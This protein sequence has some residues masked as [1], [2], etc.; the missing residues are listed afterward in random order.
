MRGR[1]DVGDCG[2]GPGRGNGWDDVVEVTRSAGS[3]SQMLLLRLWRRD[4]SRRSPGVALDLDLIASTVTEHR[5]SLVMKLAGAVIC[6]SATARRYC[7]GWNSWCSV[8]THGPIATEP[9]RSTRASEAHNLALRRRATLT[10]RWARA[11]IPWPHLVVGHCS[12]TAASK[13]GRK[14]SAGP[15]WLVQSGRWCRELLREVRR[16]R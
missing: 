6:L 16:G 11:S 2:D 13:R 4:P 12:S 10:S 14:R 9:R 8:F 7:R 5:R 3:G 1:R 15:A